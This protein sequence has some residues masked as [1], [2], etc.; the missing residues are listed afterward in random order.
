M[1]GAGTP[2]VSGRWYTLMSAMRRGY[3]SAKNVQGD[4]RIIDV[5]LPGSYQASEGVFDGYNRAMALVYVFSDPRTRCHFTI[6][7]TT[8]QT[9]QKSSESWKP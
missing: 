7:T 6:R 5:R 3:N 4:K 1:M 9:V 2:E 8:S